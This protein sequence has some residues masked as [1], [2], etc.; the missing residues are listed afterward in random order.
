MIHRHVYRR[1][2]LTDLAEE[3]LPI[4]WRIHRE[5][6]LV[7][8]WGRAILMQLAHPL[9]AAGVAEHSQFDRE[10]HGRQHRANAT[11][12][13]FLALSFGGREDAR[14][15]A[16]S[17]NDIHHHVHGRL[18]EGSQ[19]F[20]EGTEYSATNREL[21]AWV[22][23]TLVD[24][25]L[26]SYQLLVGALTR[27]EQDQ[28]CADVRAL[29]P[30]L[31]V[32]AHMLPGSVDELRGYMDEM[33]QRGEIEV[34]DT[35]RQLAVPLLADGSGLIER[36]LVG[37]F[38][39]FSVATLPS[40]LRRAYGFAP[41]AHEARSLDW[42]TRSIHGTLPWLPSWV[43]YWPEAR[44]AIAEGRQPIVP[45]LSSDVSRSDP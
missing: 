22:H 23:A 26:L 41:G 45:G 15:S 36:A 30:W 5:R 16:H 44:R 37:P 32:P 1:A 25:F 29:G 34:T 28:Y 7:L 39:L 9:V 2:V 33:V 38:R 20:P 17:I 27:V 31:G 14:A 12:H 4:S 10:P 11:I 18:K 8:G 13:A 40:S 19:Q 6:A 43:R 35:A 21:E 42:L 24:S 3:R